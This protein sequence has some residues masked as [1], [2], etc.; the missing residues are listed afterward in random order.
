M[1]TFLSEEGATS[2]KRRKLPITKSKENE[3]ENMKTIINNSTDT[4]HKHDPSNDG[5]SGILFG[6]RFVAKFSEPNK[7]TLRFLLND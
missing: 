6:P 7:L 1:G 3:R 5:R 4:P 2:T